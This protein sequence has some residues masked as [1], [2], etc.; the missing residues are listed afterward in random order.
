MYV[1]NLFFLSSLILLGIKKNVTTIGAPTS[2]ICCTG[3]SGA[4]HGSGKDSNIKRWCCFGIFAQYDAT[5][6]ARH[7]SWI[8][9]PSQNTTDTPMFF[10]FPLTLEI[11]FTYSHSLYSHALKGTSLISRRGS[12]RRC[13]RSTWKVSRWV[14]A[15]GGA[16]PTGEKEEGRM[17]KPLVVRTAAEAMPTGASPPCYIL[18]CGCYIYDILM[19]KF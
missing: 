15:A 3:A 18:E 16:M 14:T 7:E 17:Y 13:R 2:A 11:L 8:M 1:S 6:S 9:L 19:L 10:Y 5:L 12:W 4:L